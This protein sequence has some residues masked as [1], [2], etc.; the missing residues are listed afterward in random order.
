LRRLDVAISDPPR[1]VDGPPPYL[2]S[3]WSLSYAEVPDEW[4][5]TVALWRG[6][7]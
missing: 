6:A 4:L 2:P 7:R 1:L 3:H 5:A